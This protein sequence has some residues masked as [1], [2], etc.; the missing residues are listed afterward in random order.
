MS[1]SSKFHSTVN[2]VKAKSKR[3]AQKHPTATRYGRNALTGAIT[4]GTSNYGRGAAEHR[5]ARALIKHK[6]VGAKL[7]Q[8]K[9]YVYGFSGA[10]LGAGIGVA[11][12]GVSDYAKARSNRRFKR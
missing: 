8:D 3:I 12:T 11:A 5:T 7:P 6:V 10:V 9:P 4:G 2:N 1:R